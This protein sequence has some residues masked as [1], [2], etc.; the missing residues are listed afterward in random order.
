VQQISIE[1][2]KKNLPVMTV[3]ISTDEITNL[4]KAVTNHPKIEADTEDAEGNR[5]RFLANEKEDWE[6]LTQMNVADLKEA[7]NK[8]VQDHEGGEEDIT[9][10][11]ILNDQLNKFRKAMAQG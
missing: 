7:V 2:D 8:Y 5:F 10:M 4:K 9:E 6:R 11:N 3:D 1:K